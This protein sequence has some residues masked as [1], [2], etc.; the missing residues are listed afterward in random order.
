MAWCHRGQQAIT[1][2]IPGA[3]VDPNLHVCRYMALLAGWVNVS[4]F[5]D[6]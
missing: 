1:P 2:D 5:E 6:A 3:N 4:H